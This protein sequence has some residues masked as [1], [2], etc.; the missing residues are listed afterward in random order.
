MKPVREYL[1]WSAIA[2]LILVVTAAGAS[3]EAETAEECYK[4][5]KA[6]YDEREYKEAYRFISTAA[7]QG[8]AP[9]Q[10]KLG[11]MYHSGRGARQN[12]VEAVRWFKR[13]AEK[14]DALAQRTLGIIYENGEG[15][16][17]SCV[18]AVKWYRK[19]AGRGDAKAQYKLGVMYRKGECVRQDY[20]E[21]VRWY[22]ISAEHGNQDAQ[23]FLW[24]RHEN[25][26]S[27]WSPDSPA[28]NEST[29]AAKC[30]R[31]GMSYDEVAAAMY[32][33]DKSAVVYDWPETDTTLACTAY[34]LT[35]QCSFPIKFDRFMCQFERRNGVLRLNGLVFTAEY[36]SEAEALVKYKQLEEFINVS[37]P[38]PYSGPAFTSGVASAG[39]WSPSA[40]TINILIT[41]EGSDKYILRFQYR[42]CRSYREPTPLALF[43]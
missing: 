41:G 11:F 23:E 28:P 8:H 15:V 7:E 36:P 5:G 42:S 12:Q 22:R 32:V 4:K 26:E 35:Y 18:E 39:W 27:E 31:I 19:A 37:Q 3:E 13:A 10:T 9:A 21:S 38:V 1:C 16:G 33:G 29:G 2:C 43:P 25:V 20:A 24:L 30:L 14:G 34:E 17:E 6:L 40:P